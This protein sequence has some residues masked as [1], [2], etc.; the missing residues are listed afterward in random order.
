MFTQGGFAVVALSVL[1]FLVPLVVGALFLIALFRPNYRWKLITYRR[2]G[3]LFLICVACEAIV[4]LMSAFQSVRFYWK[5]APYELHLDSV[6]LWMNWAAVP[7]SLFS[8]SFVYVSAASLVL[9]LLKN[10]GVDVVEAWGTKR[11][12]LDPYN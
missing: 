1:S 4:G 7:F 6:T 3:V 11:K 9:L 5:D 2:A 10:N 12:G 8:A